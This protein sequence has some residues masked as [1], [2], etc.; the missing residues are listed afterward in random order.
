M[1]S[2]DPSPFTTVAVVPPQQNFIPV[3]RHAA[4]TTVT[5]PVTW[6]RLAKSLWMFHLKVLVP[7]AASEKSSTKTTNKAKIGNHCGLDTLSNSVAVRIA[8]KL[9]AKHGMGFPNSG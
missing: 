9:S 3:Q 5:I 7:T 1:V 4:N 6:M 2:L 8:K